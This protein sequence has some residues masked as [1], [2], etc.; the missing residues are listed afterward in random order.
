M[1]GHIE[2]E[3]S[4]AWTLDTG[5]FGIR[6]FRFSAPLSTQSST[7]TLCNAVTIS[8]WSFVIKTTRITLARRTATG[9]QW[10]IKTRY[11][12]AHDPHVAQIFGM[13]LKLATK[14]KFLVHESLPGIDS[15]WEVGHTT[16]HTT[17]M[18]DIGNQAIQLNEGSYKNMCILK[19]Q[20]LI[21]CNYVIRDNQSVV[22]LL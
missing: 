7:W 5:S 1:D 15:T 22:R 9:G 20:L 16:R 3:L 13:R 14:P 10:L 17:N 8:L 2:L 12:N 18:T 6:V 11:G 4:S 21:D 19:L